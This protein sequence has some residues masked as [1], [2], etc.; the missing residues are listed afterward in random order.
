MLNISELKLLAIAATLYYTTYTTTTLQVDQRSVSQLTVTPLARIPTSSP[1]LPNQS[2]AWHI[3]KTLNPSQIPLLHLRIEVPILVTFRP[4]VTK[5]DTNEVHKTSR[6]LFSLQTF[7]LAFWL[8]KIMV[9]PIAATTTI[10]WG[11]LLY[12][13]KNA[14][15]LEAQRN[16]AG[17]NLPDLQGQCKITEGRIAFSTLP[18]V[19]TS[20]VEHI[21]ASKDGNVVISVGIHNE[22][23]I[24]WVSERTHVSIDA[25]EALLRVTSTSSTILTITCVAVDER[26]H[27]CAVGTSTGTIAV[28]V[29]DKECVRAQP[30]LFTDNFSSSVDEIQFPLIPSPA[31]PQQS[32]S[33]TGPATE[34]GLLAT[35][36][37]GL[38]A[39]WSLQGSVTYFT[40]SHSAV[41]VKCSLV[42]VHS[43]SRFLIAFGLADGTL[44]LLETR[45]IDPWILPE[46]CVQAG[47]PLSIPTKV[48]ACEAYLGGSSRRI[49]AVATETGIVSLWD[50]STA[51]CIS[52]FDDAFGRINHLQVMPTKCEICHFCGQLPLE[53]VSVAFSVDHVIRFFRLYLNDQTRRCSCSRRP[54]RHVTCRDAVSRRPRSN[55]SALQ[56]GSSAVSPSIPRGRLAMTFKA[57]AFPV[58]AHGVHSRRMS[59]KESGRRSSDMPTVPLPTEE[60]NTDSRTFLTLVPSFWHDA[61]LVQITDIACERG[62]W[63]VHDERLVGVRRRPRS[64]GNIRGG[65][66]TASNLSSSQGL[67]A[68]I[69]ERWELWTFDPSASSFQ[70]S[71]LAALTII[72]PPS[73]PPATNCVSR[74]PF[75]RVSP[76]LIASQH[77]FAGLGNTI[78]IFYFS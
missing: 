59:E 64:Q 7:R 49:I 43:L 62:G 50:G 26:G 35:Y 34:F 30:L 16:R 45:D 38:A 11:L 10:L 60:H 31:I 32:S 63:G 2:A 75:T 29:L 72:Q 6:F 54:S 37:G 1:H 66:M 55:S 36:E 70:S 67:T 58:S 17:P 40:P 68:A 3:W 76:L 9:F 39:E 74:L 21:A 56:H 27:Y 57:P 78:G 23:T 41:A 46:F 51:E 15:L 42:C 77:A 44:E 25:L 20:D 5:G 73:S 65:M 19:F 61:V 33:R 71:L 22:V 24:W 12:L 18:R 13:L 8:L 4:V 53:S 48:H 52:V 28:W 14:E 69:L 47:D